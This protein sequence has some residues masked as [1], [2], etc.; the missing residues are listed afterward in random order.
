MMGKMLKMQML[1]DED[2]LAYET[3]KKER[4]SSTSDAQPAWM[5][6]LHTT[7]CNWLQLM[8]QTVNPLKRT[9][10]NIKDPLF[11]FFEREVKMGGKMLQEVRQDLSDVVQVCEGKKKQTNYLRT[12]ISDLVKGILPRSWCRY[13]VPASMTVIQWVADFSE[14]IKQLQQISQGAASGGAKELKVVWLTDLEKH[15]A[16]K[17]SFG[18][19]VF[20]LF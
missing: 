5:R 2:D 16:F 18:F 6:T 10:E 11:R 20:I 17:C 8:P 7:A 12:L 9:V 4:T 3:E 13:T 1:E 14:R 19:A 15:K